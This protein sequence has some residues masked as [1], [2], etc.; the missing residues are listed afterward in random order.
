MQMKKTLAKAK[1]FTL[2]ELLLVIA[3]I[4]ILALLIF[5]ALDPATRFADARDSRRFSDVNN[6]LT[7]IKV[8]QVDNKGP[9]LASITSATAS[10]VYMVGTC[11]TG[12]TT[13]VTNYLCTTEPTQDACADLTGLVTDGYLG[14]I[15]ISPDGTATWSAAN[16]GYT[17]AKAANGSVTIRACEDENTTEI[18]LTR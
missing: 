4:A 18:T 6:I 2:I 5:V 9:Y 3:I 17:I 1:G 16:T 8:D 15:P 10:E 14:S 12:A 11:T 7:A 13:T